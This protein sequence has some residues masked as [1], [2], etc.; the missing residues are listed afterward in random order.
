MKRAGRPPL[1]P[2]E[3]LVPV[4]AGLPRRH[5]DLLQRH[6]TQRHLSLAEVLRRIVAQ[7]CTPPK[8]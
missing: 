3:P 2:T 5:V 8:R 4:S 1:T 6:A 7:A